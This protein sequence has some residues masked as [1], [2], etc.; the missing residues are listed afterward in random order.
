MTRFFRNPLLSS[1]KGQWRPIRTVAAMSARSGQV[2]YRRDRALG[3]VGR[4]WQAATPVVYHLAAALALAI[5]TLVVLRYLRR[6]VQ[7][8]ITFIDRPPV[9]T[10][11]NQPA[12]MS[13][14][15]AQEICS[16][17]QPH[18]LHSAFDHQLLVDASRALA[19]NPW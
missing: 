19:A 18:G 11:L 3:W 16:A 5:I 14:T 15:L 4:A 6:D 8:R 17:A 7:T 1:D 2:V 12:W 13:D 10:L 9:V